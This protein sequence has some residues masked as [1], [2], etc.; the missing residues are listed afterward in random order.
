M[1]FLYLPSNS[2]MSMPHAQKKH[3]KAY[4]LPGKHSP[5]RRSSSARASARM[6]MPI[7]R[8]PVNEAMPN[9]LPPLLHQPTST[10]ESRTAS[11]DDFR[12]Q[13]A[14]IVHTAQVASFN[15][16]LATNRP[17][18]GEAEADLARTPYLKEQIPSSTI[19]ISEEQRAK[20]RRWIQHVRLVKRAQAFRLNIRGAG[21]RIN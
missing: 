2:N 21:C 11:S 10:L 15:S 8:Q 13:Y 6:S 4:A 19:S 12:E 20:F 7:S 18:T 16:S 14:C 5:S 1:A 3:S 9:P 17:S